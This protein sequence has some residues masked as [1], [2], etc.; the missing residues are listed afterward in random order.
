M[1][2]WPPERGVLLLYKESVV[3]QKF[4]LGKLDFLACVLL[5]R[6]DLFSNIMLFNYLRPRDINTQFD[7]SF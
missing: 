1:V 5:D 2:A 3:C 6:S 7:V 4:H